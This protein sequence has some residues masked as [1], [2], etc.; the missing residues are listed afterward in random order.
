M[1]EKKAAVLGAL[2][3]DTAKLLSAIEGLICIETIP[4]NIPVDTDCILIPCKSPDEELASL[5]ARV[6][7]RYIPVGIITENASSDELEQF[8]DMG[9]DDIITLPMPLRLVSKRIAA[10]CSITA[11][12]EGAVDFTLFDKI[13]D[14][15]SGIGSF[16]IQENDFANIYRFVLRMLER[17]DKKSQLLIFN[18]HE[19]HYISQSMHLFIRISSVY[20]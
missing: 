15:N 7:E 6:K 1:F 19:S 9:A 3:P 2:S 4:G 5:I 20:Q 8:L 18:M 14:S 16:I 11:F 12:D 10:L 17:L 13:A